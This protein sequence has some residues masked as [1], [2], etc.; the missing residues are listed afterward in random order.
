M[1]IFN[2]F[3]YV[4]QRVSNTTKIFFGLKMLGR[5]S[6]HVR[7]HHHFPEK[8]GQDIAPHFEE[9][10]QNDKWMWVKMED[11]TTIDPTT[12]YL[13]FC[14]KSLGNPKTYM[15]MGQYL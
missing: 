12:W 6:Q 1:A 7:F 4:H 5:L 2:C 14:V 3:L 15:G 11:P 8:I 13:V 10:P 9:N